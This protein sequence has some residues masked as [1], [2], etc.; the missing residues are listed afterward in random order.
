M[1]FD[2][3]RIV[4]SHL[5]T[6]RFGSWPS[7]H[8]AEVLQLTLD[9]GGPDLVTSLHVFEMTSTVTTDGF[10]ELQ[11]HTVVDLRFGGIAQL[12]LTEF[13][14]QNAL[15]GLSLED[16]TAH[17]LEHLRWQV[18]LDA[19]NGLDAT[20]VCRTISVERASDYVPGAVLA[21]PSGT[22]GGPRHGSF[23]S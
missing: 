22:Q 1:S 21:S 9:R 7:F 10:Y 5:L 13:N 19:A 6:D 20:F 17:Q 14:H 15:M 8:D 12:E 4:D 16:I 3:N 18:S 23:R 11:N 2:P